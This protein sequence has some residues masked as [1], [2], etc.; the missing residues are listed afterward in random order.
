MTPG[1]HGSPPSQWSETD[2]GA[3]AAAFVSVSQAHL[4]CRGG[5]DGGEWRRPAR[6]A[7]S[8]GGQQRDRGLLGGVHLS[9]Q[10][11][12]ARWRQAGDLRRRSLPWRGCPRGAHQG[13][14]QA[15]PGQHLVA[16]SRPFRLQP[17]AVRPQAARLLRSSRLSRAWSPPPCTRCSPRKP[18][19]RSSHAGMIWPPRWRSAAFGPR[20]LHHG[21]GRGRRSGHRIQSLTK[22]RATITRCQEATSPSQ[23]GN[24]LAPAQAWWIYEDSS[25]V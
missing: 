23:D 15:A 7:G 8:Q 21:K 24:C 19:R 20:V 2:C 9:P 12:W 13:D 10:G 22:T 6:T 3:T 11:A 17:A 18:Q 5:G 16:L 14:P 25:Q 4:S 1:S